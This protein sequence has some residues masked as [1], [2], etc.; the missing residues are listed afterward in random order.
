MIKRLA[1]D[2]NNWTKVDYKNIPFVI[3]NEDRQVILISKDGGASV[4][5]VTDSDYKDNPTSQGSLYLKTRDKIQANV[6][7]NDMFF[8]RK[9]E[10]NL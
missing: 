2:C 10:T 4:D 3:E 5:C 7:F 9:K 1:I 6:V 8:T